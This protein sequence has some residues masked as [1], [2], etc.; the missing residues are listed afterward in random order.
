MEGALGIQ[1]AAPGA[2]TTQDLVHITAGDEAYLP[3]LASQAHIHLC[4]T[5]SQC[6][7]CRWHLTKVDGSAGRVVTEHTHMNT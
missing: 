5:L 7:E 1:S 3:T 6:N 4:H 2:A